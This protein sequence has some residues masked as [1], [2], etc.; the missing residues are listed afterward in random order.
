MNKK[1]ILFVIS[2][3]SGA[4][5]GTLVARLLKSL[6][7]HDLYFSVSCATRA[8]RKGEIDGVHYNFISKAEFDRLVSE[9]RFLEY[10]HYCRGDYGTLAEPV[11]MALE[12]G[13]SSILEIDCNGMRQVKQKCPEAVTV[14]ISPPS[15]EELENRLRSRGTESE[16][17]ICK[18]I[19]AAASEMEQSDE[20]D[21]V[22]VNDDLDRAAEELSG[23]FEKY[24]AD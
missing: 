6:E 19:A 15:V 3:P 24:L 5:K 1:G 22:V 12:E 18:R 20:Y 11:F 7:H 10:N 8:P 9:D 2:G 4:G 14:F 17:L 13:K 16:E 21:H 23:I